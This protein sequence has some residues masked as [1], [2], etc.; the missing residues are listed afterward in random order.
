MEG[1]VDDVG[2]CSMLVDI[3]FVN[4]G[5]D[6]SMAEID[7]YSLKLNVGEL[8]IEMD[9]EIENVSKLLCVME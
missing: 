8:L 5:F 2:V 6:D 7:E 3:E 4:V 1:I 9:V